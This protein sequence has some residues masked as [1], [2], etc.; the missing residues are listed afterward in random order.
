MLKSA[1][2]DNLTENRTVTEPTCAPRDQDD[3]PVFTASDNNGDL[4]SALCGQKDDAEN[5]END[6]KDIFDEID[7]T[8][9][10]RDSFGKVVKESKSQAN[11]NALENICKEDDE[12][13]CTWITRKSDGSVATSADAESVNGPPVRDN[14]STYSASSRDSA[15]SRNLDEALL[16]AASVDVT[17]A[18]EHDSN[19]AI[20]TEMNTLAPLPSN[21]DSGESAEL[22]FPDSNTSKCIVYCKIHQLRYKYL[23]HFILS[24]S[25]DVEEVISVAP[26][27]TTGEETYCCVNPARDRRCS[28]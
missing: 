3:L 27:G 11:E 7:K 4:L 22:K 15:V 2:C 8:W 9:I 16:S 25:I 20:Y 23:M 26:D 1:D 17:S 14:N 6:A 24:C 5:N 28:N 19:N 13:K 10:I 18:I 12:V 21:P